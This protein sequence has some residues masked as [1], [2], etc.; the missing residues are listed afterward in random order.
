MRPARGPVW[1]VAVTGLAVATF[2]AGVVVGAADPPGGSRGRLVEQALTAISTHADPGATPAQL[3]AGAIAGMLATLNDPY[4]FYD[5]PGAGTA[6]YSGLSLAVAGRYSGIGLWLR[7]GPGGSVVIGSVLPASPAAA[8]GLAAGQRILAVGGETTAGMGLPMVAL[9][10]QG[11]PGS[12]VSLTVAQGATQWQVTLRRAVLPDTNVTA[13]PVAAGVWRIRVAEFSSGVAAAVRTALHRALAAGARGVV[14]DLRANPGGLLSEAIATA[15][16]FLNGGPVVELSGR[17]VRTEML[18]APRGG[19]TTVPLVVLVD[20]G[21]ASAAEVVAGALQQRGRAVLVGSRTY[22]KGSVQQPIALPGG[23]T[24]SMTVAHYLTP[25]GTDIN[26][27]GLTPD[28]PLAPRLAPSVA[29]ATA[30]AVV[31]GLAG[32]SA[33]PAAAVGAG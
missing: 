12:V 28:V 18:D 9:E 29:L 5:Q 25:D 33:E 10:L 8:G 21:T 20:G 13:A 6:G 27:V 32:G 7:P 11:R 19:D 4:A 30:I 3:E 2:A 26:G 22:G 14:L 31:E 17:A 15:G 1:A 24:I 23:G 16:V